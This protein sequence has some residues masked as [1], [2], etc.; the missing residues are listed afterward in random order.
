MVTVKQKVYWRSPYFLKC[1]MASRYGRE[2][3]KTRFG[4]AYEQQV[5]GILDRDTWSAERLLEY[6]LQAL[7]AMLA[8]AAAH[9]PY[10]RRAF[11]E[12]GVSAL[13]V[14]SVADLARLPIL[15]KEPIRTRPTELL[16]ERLDTRK[17]VFLHTSGTTGTP[18]LLWRDAECD[19]TAFAYLDAR[20]HRVAG[21]QRRKNR[22]VSIGGHQ[23]TDPERTKPPFWV[24]NRHWDQLYMSSYHLSPRYLDH[25]IQPILDFRPDY[26]EGIP[27]SVYAVARYILD[28]GLDPI[29][30]KVAFTSA[31]SLFDYQRETIKRAFGCRTYDQYGCGE[32][33][34]F[35]A[36]CEH[37]SMHLSPDYC[38]VEVV[39]GNDNPVP[40][41]ESG[42]LIVT[43]LVNTTQPF[44]R[45]RV[46][47]SGSLQPG[48]C[49]CGRPLPMLGS[50][51]GR[52]DDAVIAPDGRRFFT[53]GLA[54][55][56]YDL[57]GI[58][59]TQLVQEKLGELVVRVVPGNDYKD[60]TGQALARVLRHRLG[61]QM[62][63]RVELVDHIERTCGGKSRLILS[64]ISG[65]QR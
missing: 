12:H 58:L 28:K 7:Q 8:H 11:S 2:R 24:L 6:Q 17:L 62:E 31:E 1:W 23:V 38:V 33:A 39:D 27:S 44:I 37:G 57:D 22:S 45:Y 32:L 19:S 26:I 21:M 61:S 55:A 50:I 59:E 49:P 20:W 16:D 14:R 63:I 54:P 48:V 30:I 18:L 34:V 9:V 5:K 40:P 29:P 56:F 60:A 10:Y 65:G 52:L 47:D 41:G 64:R 36:E 13:D 4:A 43:S 51:G 3:D 25:Y 15:E 53:A 35:C 42:T 46:G